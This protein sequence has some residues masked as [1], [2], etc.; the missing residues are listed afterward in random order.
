[1]TIEDASTFFEA[2]PGVS[3]KLK[4]LMD[5]TFHMSS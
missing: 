2:I 3:R 1:M 4:T 5:V